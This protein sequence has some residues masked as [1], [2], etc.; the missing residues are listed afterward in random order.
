MKIDLKCF[1]TLV[2]QDHCD[3]SK[4][5]T[6]NI[7]TGQTVTSL[8]SRAGVAREDVKIVF[9]N[10]RIAGLDTILKDGDRVALAPASGGM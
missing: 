7:R 6:F 5:N 4:F 1:S 3:F 9:I 8:L 10:N 2:R